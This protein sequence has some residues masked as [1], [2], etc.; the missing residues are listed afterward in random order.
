ML[1]ENIKK[2]YLGESEV[3]KMYLGENLIYPREPAVDDYV[4]LGTTTGSTDFMIGSS[5]S[6]TGR[7]DCIKVHVVQNPGGINTM[8]VK[9]E[10]VLKTPV[11]FYGDYSGF[12]SYEGKKILSID[13]WN[14][15]TS[16]VTRIDFM[17]KDCRE[18]K[19]VDLRGFNTSKV[20]QMK[21][22]FQNCPSLVSVDL[23]DFN[24]ENVTSIDY[25]FD[26]CSSLDS[27]DVSNFNTINVTSMSNIFGN[28]NNLTEL[29]LRAF[30]TTNCSSLYL[31]DGSYKINKLYLSRNFFNSKT[32]SYVFNY[33]YYWTDPESLAMFVEAITA[34][35]GGGKEVCFVEETYNA[36]T[37]TQKN[38]IKAK[39]WSISYY[40][41]S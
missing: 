22:L 31:F 35:D 8:Y 29:D 34:H 32:D 28:C 9:Q 11:C 5:T 39:G 16:N 4:M 33:L 1:S 18:L 21:S 41:H 38:A 15:D 6:I 30:D 3:Q 2:I 25:M 13:K 20:T 26:G 37:R 12:N 19:K 40:V 36:L 27:L 7:S 24:T 10:D 17:F 23:S 14:I